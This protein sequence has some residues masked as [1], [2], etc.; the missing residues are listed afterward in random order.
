MSEAK[1]ETDFGEFDSS[2]QILNECLNTSE[3][4]I[5]F[6]QDLGLRLKAEILHKLGRNIMMASAY[7]G[8]QEE[9]IR[10]AEAYINDSISINEQF[11]DNH[12][13]LAANIDTFGEIDLRK[14]DYGAAR[15]NFKKA[16]LLRDTY[17]ADHNL[18]GSMEKERA[19]NLCSIAACDSG[20]GDHGQ[21]L[22]NYNS[23]LS[24]YRGL[25][26]SDHNKYSAIAIGNMSKVYYKLNERGKTREC[27]RLATDIL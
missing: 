21:A 12:I 3:Q 1:I 5:K 20:I 26:G 23:A 22:K 15:T 14:Q 7:G 13:A 4:K 17:S 2:T 8:N 18:V 9:G 10:R 24:I 19:D 27:L 6:N 16:Q 25:Y 11:D